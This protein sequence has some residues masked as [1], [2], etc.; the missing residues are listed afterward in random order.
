MDLN[1]IGRLRMNSIFWL[2]GVIVVALAAL[3]LVGAA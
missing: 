1:A 3:S 2:I